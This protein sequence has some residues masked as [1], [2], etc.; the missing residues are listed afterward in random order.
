M[1]Q[2]EN[3]ASMPKGFSLDQA[4]AEAERCLLCHDAPCSTGCPAG[5]D[6]GT[7]I[8][9]LRLKNIT[10]AIRTIKENNILGGAC[11]VLCPAARLCEQECCAT[12]ISRPI[13]IAKIQRCLIEH[14]WD[15][16][17]KLLSAPEKNGSQV[18]VVGSGP[19]GLSCA[20]EL[21][22][23]GCQ[24]T[25]FEA[26]SEPGGVIRYGVPSYR[27]DADFF[28]HELQEIK[29]LG[30]EIRC[31]APIRGEGE[32]E[33]LLQNGY[34]A[35]FLA[36]GLW[37][38]ARL[39]PEV[40]DVDGLLSSVEFLASLRDGQLE[41]LRDRIKGSTVAVIG[42]GSV[43]IDCAESAAKL[44]ARDV[45]L[46]YR[47]SF[48]QMPAEKSEQIEAL[49]SGVHFLVLNQPVDFVIN[50]HRKIEAIRLVRTR[51]AET[52]GNGRRT[53]ETIPGTEWV[54]NAD[55]VI[56]AIG[57]RA[58]TDSSRW[59]PNVQVDGQRLIQTDSSTCRTSVEG[60]FAGGDIVRGP[61]LVVEA[62]QDGK[63]AARG[64][65]EYLAGKE[66]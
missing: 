36:T 1:E 10:G 29:S 45:Y 51:L 39:K 63:T 17:L 18:A 24:V 62:V 66:V 20:A 60:I 26:H 54:L 48:T 12:E 3:F 8:R 43:A 22:K 5:T 2:N 34:A 50:H 55:I 14:S 57:N 31:D 25:I 15:R 53:P 47:R 19:A 65:M 40:A 27:Y 4:I 30:V 46:V 33:R 59:Y 44:G 42:G 9:K 11:G 41:V 56:E 6:P 58:V 64:I 61:G 23:R 35:V 13:E 32:A 28:A 16:G 38:A 49:E 52:S 21:A 37:G 7:F